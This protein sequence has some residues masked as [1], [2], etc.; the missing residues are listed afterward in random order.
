MAAAVAPQQ[1][2]S[3][4]CSLP[5]PLMTPPL[6][7]F[8][9][10]ASLSETQVQD[11]RAR[12]LIRLGCF[13]FFLIVFCSERVE[14][15]LD[16]AHAFALISRFVCP[17]GSVSWADKV[18]MAPAADRNASKPPGNLR[19]GH[20]PSAGG[21][22]KQQ[23]QQ[24]RQQRGQQPAEGGRQPGGHGRLH[25]ALSRSATAAQSTELPQPSL[26][27]R[28]AAE[29]GDS[30]Q[31]APASDQPAAA[32]VDGP[33]PA[34]TA[35]PALEE[36]AGAAS[37]VVPESGAD[38]M[39]GAAAGSSALLPSRSWAAVAAPAEP[40]SLAMEDRPAEPTARAGPSTHSNGVAPPAKERPVPKAEHAA[41]A[42]KQSEED[43]WTQVMR[44]NSIVWPNRSW[45]SNA[46][47]DLPVQR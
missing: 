12:S 33:A 24:R 14:G 34:E 45:S 39:G 40:A 9:Q 2:T 47:G 38:S 26:D 27:R 16:V 20:A 29:A 44:C 15:R 17:A 41:A 11:L 25:S 35:G 1:V 18:K 22:Q 46:F 6:A 23:P 42:G 19:A 8:T 7:Q 31:E 36:T 21:H 37:A 13:D 32:A 30:S 28:S 4:P 43:G 10:R 5:L 3:P